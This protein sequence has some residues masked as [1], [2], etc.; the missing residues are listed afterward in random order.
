MMRV[1]CAIVMLVAFGGLAFAVN[2]ME[3]PVI[4]IDT[5][6]PYE[7]SREMLY[8]QPPTSGFYTKNA[9]SGFGSEFAD[10][11]WDEYGGGQWFVDEVVV[12]V[13]EWGADWVDPSGVVMNLY[14]GNCPPELDAYQTY[15]FPWGDPAYMDM[16]WVNDNPSSYDL[17]VTLYIDPPFQI[18]APMSIGFYVDNYWGEDPPYCGIDY[19]ETGDIYGC[20]EGYLDHDYWGFP[21]WTTTGVAGGASTDLAYCLNGTGTTGTIES[22][23]SLV[24]N[25][26]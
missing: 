1:L 5:S 4:G 14:A 11:I 19:T 10:D 3:E 21:R 22:T 15:Y 12:Y 7:P 6:K 18:I 9:S 26:Y 17:E 25:L 8:C 24:K 16:I 23:W 13:G 20:G 2:P